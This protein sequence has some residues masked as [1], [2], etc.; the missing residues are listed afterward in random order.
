MPTLF[1]SFQYGHLTSFRNDLRLIYMSTR[2]IWLEY[3]EVITKCISDSRSW[4][5]K[6][7]K[8]HSGTKVRCKILTQL[9][10]H[11]SDMIYSLFDCWK[12]HTCLVPSLAFFVVILYY[13]SKLLKTACL[14]LPR[15]A[16]VD[17]L[18][19]HLLCFRFVIN[20]SSN[21]KICFP[22]KTLIW[23]YVP[24]RRGRGH[25]VFG[26]DPVGVGVSVSV[27]VSVTLSCLHDISWTGRWILTKFAWM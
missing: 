8:K 14:I 1:P 18:N 23:N 3:R 19:D 4:C 20:C 2:F 11:H 6:L 5:F 26:A 17:R 25:I 10:T 13:P 24:H 27:G 12:H 15:W 9:N 7:I 22:R 16:I 21:L